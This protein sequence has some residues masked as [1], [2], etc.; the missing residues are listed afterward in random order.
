MFPEE[1]ICWLATRSTRGFEYLHDSDGMVYD[2]Q[3]LLQ[4]E[5]TQSTRPTV[6]VVPMPFRD[7]LWSCLNFQ[8]VSQGARGHFVCCFRSKNRPDC[9]THWLKIWA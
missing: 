4:L 9:R 6:T 8:S 3:G 7:V 2:S 5:A 1:R